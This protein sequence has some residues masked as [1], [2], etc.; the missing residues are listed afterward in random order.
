MEDPKL[1][2]YGKKYYKL[3]LILI[4]VTLAWVS[5]IVWAIFT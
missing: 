2:G 4:A 5:V 3:P 1:K